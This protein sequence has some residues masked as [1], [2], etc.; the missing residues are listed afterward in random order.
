[1]ARNAQPD[2][3]EFLEAQQPAGRKSL[4]DRILAELSDDQRTRVM[5]ALQ[6]ADIGPDTISTVL[7][8]WGYKVSGSAIH[9][10]RKANGWR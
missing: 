10:Y 7:G 3:T 4:M 6:S 5:A 9:Y 1:M 8:R 2:L